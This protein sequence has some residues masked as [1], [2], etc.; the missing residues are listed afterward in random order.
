VSWS[1]VVVENSI[2]GPKF[3]PF[4]THSFTL[5]LQC[6]HVISLV[7]YLALWNEFKVNDTLD[8]EESDGNFHHLPR[9]S[10]LL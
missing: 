10:D 7:G 6:F 5:P 2:N 9:P 8:I 1:I 4:S 3:K